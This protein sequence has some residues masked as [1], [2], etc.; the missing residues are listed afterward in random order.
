MGPNLVLSLQSQSNRG[1]SGGLL[2]ALLDEVSRCLQD[3]TH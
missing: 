3:P 1:F 2:L